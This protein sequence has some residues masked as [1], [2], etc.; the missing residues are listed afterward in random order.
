M[1]KAKR[2]RRRLTDPVVYVAASTL[3]HA[4]GALSP[5]AQY[6]LASLAATLLWRSGPNRRRVVNAVRL[7][8]E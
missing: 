3:M 4:A 6:R 8:A 2:W 5:A 1:I 7:S